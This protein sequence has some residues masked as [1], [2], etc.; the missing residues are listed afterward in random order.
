L[1]GICFVRYHLK[2]VDLRHDV[3]FAGIITALD[4]DLLRQFFPLPFP[5][6]KLLRTV[7][8]ASHVSITLANFENE[9]FIFSSASAQTEKEF[10]VWPTDDNGLSISITNYTDAFW[11]IEEWHS[12]KAKVAGNEEW[13]GYH[14]LPPHGELECDTMNV[15]LKSNP[16][17]RQ[18]QIA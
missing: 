14:L 6:G 9:L 8:C 7:T 5:V 12:S 2:D 15:C 1:H 13:Q 11:N 17:F 16:R 10:G 18:H 3:S 4:R